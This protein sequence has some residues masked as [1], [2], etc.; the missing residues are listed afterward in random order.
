MM[1][2]RAAME[3]AQLSVPQVME[4]Q[5]EKASVLGTIIGRFASDGLDVI[6]DRTAELATEGG[7][8]PEMPQIMLE[9]FGGQE[10]KYDYI[11]PLAQMQKRLFRTQGI[12]SGLKVMG[13]LEAIKPGTMDLIDIDYAAKELLESFG[14]P[15]HG[16]TDENVVKQTRDARNKQ[17]QQE[18]QV[19]QAALMSQAV[20]IYPRR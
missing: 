9:L 17:I 13:E 6:N 10:L 3:G 20:P 8:M 12:M 15:A 1:L 7:R 11:G 5:S 2:S 19:K 16:F 14:W 4:M 18:A